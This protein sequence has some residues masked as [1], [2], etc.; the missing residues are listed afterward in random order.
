VI[1]IF[2]LNDDY[3]ALFHG[4]THVFV[5]VGRDGLWMILTLANL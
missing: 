5:F 4:N 2:H 3:H 1:Y